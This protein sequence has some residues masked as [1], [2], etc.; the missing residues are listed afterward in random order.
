MASSAQASTAYG[1][2][3]SGHALNNTYTVFH[4][5]PRAAWSNERQCVDSAGMYAWL[6]LWRRA[7]SSSALCSCRQSL[8]QPPRQ[9][10]SLSTRAAT[11]RSSSRA[12]LVPAWCPKA[13]SLQLSSNSAK[14]SSG[15]STTPWHCGKSSPPALEKS[16]HLKGSYRQQ[17]RVAT[18]CACEVLDVRHEPACLQSGHLV[19][20]IAT[21]AC[22]LCT[23]WLP[24][25]GRS[26]AGPPSSCLAMA[27]R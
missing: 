22:Q 26:T 20:L 21:Q 19:P 5:Q 27:H 8:S 25:P 4:A 15:R 9:P 12:P 24:T 1:C 13:P 2:S 23:T 10:F 18:T 6:A 7:P 11:S 14:S 3:K 17:E 16:V